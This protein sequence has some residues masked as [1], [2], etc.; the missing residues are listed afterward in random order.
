MNQAHATHQHAR[1]SPRKIRPLA[2][3]LRGLPVGTADRQLTFIPGKAAQ[4]VR[5][6]LASAVANATH[7]HSLIG[8]SLK[9]ARVQVEEGLKMHR[10]EP[11]SRGSA[12]P[13][14]KRTAHVTV[15]VEGALTPT[16]SGKSLTQ[17]ETISASTY[18]TEQAGQSEALDQPVQPE[19][20][21]TKLK[22]RSVETR[23]DKQVGEAFQKTKMMQ[24]GGDK[25]KSFRRKSI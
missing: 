8:D 14:I 1:M 19:Q 25:K 6:V 4:I 22:P 18:A 10:F 12:H 5:K 17:I 7:N 2:A 3:A 24:Q 9:I 15:I 21:V 13:I 20:Q 11:A 16:T 23:Q